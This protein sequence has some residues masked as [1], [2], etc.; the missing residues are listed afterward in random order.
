MKQREPAKNESLAQS[1][2]YKLFSAQRTGTA[3]KPYFH[4]APTK[5]RRFST[6]WW[7]HTW[8]TVF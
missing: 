3:T 2:Q 8:T 6:G 4:A 1:G 5:K 7:C